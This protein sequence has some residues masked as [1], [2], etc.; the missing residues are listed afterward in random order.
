[1]QDSGQTTPNTN[2][3]VLDAAGNAII[4]GQ[5][6]YSQK[7]EDADG[8][9][10][11]N[12]PTTAWNPAAPTGATGTDTAPVGTIMPFS[13]FVVPTNWAL[14]DGSTLDRTTYS[15]LYDAITISHDSVSCTSGSPVLAGWPDTSQMRV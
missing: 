3:V 4:Y 15:D 1:W 12:A 13:G 7:V 10:I 14:A 2:P 8:N 5:G 9:L 6:T 11:W